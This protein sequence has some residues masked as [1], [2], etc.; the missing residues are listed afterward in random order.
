MQDKE[1]FIERLCYMFE[2][3]LDEWKYEDINDYLGYMQK[4][5]PNAFAITKKPFGIKVKVDN[6]VHYFTTKLKGDQIEI[7]ETI[8][9]REV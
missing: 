4:F 9:E 3:W 6:K 8:I 1:K 7:K 2:R 5:E